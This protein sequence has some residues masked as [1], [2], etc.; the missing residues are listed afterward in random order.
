MASDETIAKMRRIVEVW[1]RTDIP[2]RAKCLMV[3]GLNGT[4]EDE[5]VVKKQYLNLLIEIHPEK[6]HHE[7]SNSA[8]PIVNSAFEELKKRDCLGFYARAASRGHMTVHGAAVLSD[9]NLLVEIFVWLMSI[10]DWDAAALCCRQW[11]AACRSNELWRRRILKHRPQLLKLRGV[12]DYRKLLWTTC[13]ASELSSRSFLQLPPPLSEFQ[14]IL[15]GRWF[16]HVC[17]TFSTLYIVLNGDEALPVSEEDPE[18]IAWSCELD[19]DLVGIP[20]DEVKLSQIASVTKIPMTPVPPMDDMGGPNF[21]DPPYKEWFHFLQNWAGFCDVVVLTSFHRQQACDLLERPL[22][23]QVGSLATEDNALL[24]SEANLLE[25]QA[26]SNA[27]THAPIMGRGNLQF[28][29]GARSTSSSAP[30][31]DLTT[32]LTSMSYID[33][34]LKL[35]PYEKIVKTVTEAKI[36]R[37]TEIDGAEFGLCQERFA[38]LKWLV[39]LEAHCFNLTDDHSRE[40]LTR[41]ETLRALDLLHRTNKDAHG[42]IPRA[43]SI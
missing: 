29:L 1:E 15:E 21:E 27:Q 35:T 16:D 4:L 8:L 24:E 25:W 13:L 34:T 3:L 10:D 33:F 12:V 20:Q 36:A 40:R 2:P 39:Q 6:T 17:N 22:R 43:R 42:R 5:A 23:L 18:R 37:I 19:L 28:I 26:Y 9:T 7:L 32:R 38:K 41:E 31:R 30:A 11:A 14:F